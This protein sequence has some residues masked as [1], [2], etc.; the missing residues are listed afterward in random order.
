MTPDDPRADATQLI[1]RLARCH[2]IARRYRAIAADCEERF[3]GR[4]LEVGSALRAHARVPDAERRVIDDALRELTQLIGECEAAIRSVRESAP[5]RA[6]LAAWNAGR[7][8]EVAV[9]APVIFDGVVPDILAS[10]LYLPVSVTAAGRGEHFLAA[11]VVA[12]HIALLLRDGIPQSDPPP[13]RG[14][15]EQLGVVTLDDDTES[16][17]SPIMLAIDGGSLALPTFRLQPAGE[18]LIYTPRL[19]VP[20]AVHFAAG[21]TDEWWA[22]RPDAYAGYT[23]TLARELA[24]RGVVDVDRPL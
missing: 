6:A 10:R 3:L 21:T 4:A 22:V 16:A 5:Y 11:T 14:A 7:L 13:G 15:D 24:A 18:V 19:R 17:D 12:D 1:A 23:A 2:A 20:A 9:Q 8:L